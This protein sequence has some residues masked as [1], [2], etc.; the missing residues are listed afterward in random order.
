MSAP[1]CMVDQG[2][3]QAQSLGSG[4][5]LGSQ[6]AALDTCCGLGPLVLPCSHKA[7]VAQMA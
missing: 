5:V 6:N 7:G 3:L 4:I 1:G 2:S